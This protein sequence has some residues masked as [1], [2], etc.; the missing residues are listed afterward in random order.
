MEVTNGAAEEGGGGIGNDETNCIERVSTMEIELP[1]GN[2]RRPWELRSEDP[3]LLRLDGPGSI[4]SH[5]SCDDEDD[6]D[7]NAL[8]EE[9]PNNIFDHSN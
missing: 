9:L 5:D 8:G 6:E 1:E 2:A 3:K 4:D 7:D